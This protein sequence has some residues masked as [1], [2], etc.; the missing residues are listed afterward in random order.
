MGLDVWR[1]AAVFVRLPSG[2]Y[3]PG[4]GYLLDDTYVLTARHVLHS[5]ETSAPLQDAARVRLPTLSRLDPDYDTGL[6]DATRVWSGDEETDIAILTLTPQ[7]KP[8]P[9]GLAVRWGRLPQPVQATSWPCTIVGFPYAATEVDPHNP[10]VSRRDTQQIEGVIR[11]L[12]GLERDRLQIDLTGTILDTKAVE[13]L[14]GAPVFVGD[15]LV[16]V[17]YGHLRDAGSLWATPVHRLFGPQGFLPQLPL[18]GAG[19]EEL[20]APRPRTCRALPPQYVARPDDLAR[21]RAAVE[22]TR[23][24]ALVALRGMPGSGKTVL[25]Q[26]LCADK[27]IQAA[28]PDGVLWAT[29][30]RDLVSVEAQLRQIGQ[31]LG[32]FI[33]HYTDESAGTDRLGIILRDKAVLLVLD[34]VWTAAQVRPFLV[35]APRCCLLFTTRDENVAVRSL[36]AVEVEIG[37]LAPDQAVALLRQWANRDDP[38]FAT[39][40]KRLGYLPLALRI[41]GARLRG[42]ADTPGQSGADWL[43]S[44]QHVSQIKLGYRSTDP[45]ENLAVCFDLS[46]DRLLDE[47]R[48]LYYILGIFPDDEAIPQAVIIRLWGQLKPMRSATDYADML[49]DLDG[50]GLLDRDAATQTVSLHDLLHDYTRDK[51]D[52]SALATHAALLAAYNST[53]L[54]WPQVPHDGYLYTHLAYHLLGSGQQEALYTLLTAAPDWMEAKFVACTGDTAYVADLDLALRD[55]VDP[56]APPR[57]PTLFALHAARQVV[58][59]RVRSYEDLDLSTLVWLGRDGEALSHTRLRGDP[60]TQFS[61]LLTVYDALRAK[62][63]PK[64][65]LLDEARAVAQGIS[66]EEERAW[67]LAALAGALAQAGNDQAQAVFDEARTAAQSISG[68]G[69]RAGAVAALAGAL[70]QAQRFDE[71]RTAAESISGAGE[72]YRTRALAALVGAL[73]QAQRFDEARTVAQSISDEEKRAEALRALV[74]ALSL[75]QRFDE[76]LTTLGPQLTDTFMTVFAGWASELEHIEP[77]L[78]PEVLREVTRIVGWTRP[79]WR[80]IADL[81]QAS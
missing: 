56:V 49:L 52:G 6:R 65:A 46:V 73:A 71:A 62:G 59:E 5:K 50:L 16:G 11:P 41:V 54:P 13:S 20:E 25:A 34:D 61:G 80:K 28:F 68:A 8:L 66:D 43:Q 40:A 29:L 48:D 12:G 42:T 1:C 3:S 75:R 55:F 10:A 81:L 14:S 70:A 21:V 67:A 33:G 22:A 57:L 51:L 79:D 64:L 4:S 9:E 60:G 76:A 26:A 72:W 44:F 35:D 53:G 19:V 69:K 77:G 24:P 7:G 23:L 30:G 63:Q 37:T 17:V 38:E 74:V 32:D 27:A 15:L 18:T 2:K 47:D 31:A 58:H 45:Q 36:G 78:A 39:I